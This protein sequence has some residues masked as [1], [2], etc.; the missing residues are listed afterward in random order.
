MVE[1][2]SLYELIQQ[3]HERIFHPVFMCSTCFYLFCSIVLY[4]FFYPYGLLSEINYYYYY[5]YYNT[6]FAVIDINTLFFYPGTV[7][8]AIH[9]I[10]KERSTSYILRYA[11]THSVI[12]I[13]CKLSNSFRVKICLFVI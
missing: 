7:G 2:C 11:F 10:D 4:Y 6:Q 5:Y 12:D 1:L 13:V 3:L 9:D 8:Y